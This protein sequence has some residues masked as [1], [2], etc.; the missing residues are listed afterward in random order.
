MKVCQRAALLPP[1]AAAG[2]LP[3]GRVVPQALG[4]VKAV[5]AKVRAPHR[6]GEVGH[7]RAQ[8][9]LAGAGGGNVGTQRLHVAVLHR[10]GGAVGNHVEKVAVAEL[11]GGVEHGFCL[12]GTVSRLERLLERRRDS[13]QRRRALRAGR[14]GHL[15]VKRRE[16]VHGVDDARAGQ[17]AN[18]RRRVLL[19]EPCRQRAAV[20]AANLN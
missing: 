17:R 19:A 13:L 20:A 15:L 5:G 14:R 16:L 2:G 10:H 11:S 1:P 12:R 4:V 3:L 18:A 6:F 8:V 7:E 9:V